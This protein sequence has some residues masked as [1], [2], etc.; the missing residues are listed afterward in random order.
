[1]CFFL[2]SF[3]ELAA[4]LAA[5]CVHEAG[6]VLTLA[7]LDARAERI[8]VGAS[9]LRI[10]YQR[11]LSPIEEILSALAGPL[12][13]IIWAIAAIALNMKLAAG[14]SI[15]L[16]A[17]NLLPVSV[18]DGG[19]AV[20]GLARLVLGKKASGLTS[21][22]DALFLTGICAFGLF[23]AISGYGAA[24]A[25]AGGWLVIYTLVKPRPLV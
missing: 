13:G 22:L 24:V 3:N 11:D 10:D 23:C 15:V 7:A 25:I 1:M 4:L 14:I 5:V 9:G 21:G 17:F 19:R 8:V 6:H 18:L 20:S 16:S 12:G 2:L